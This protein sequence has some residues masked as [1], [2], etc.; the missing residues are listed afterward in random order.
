MYLVFKTIHVVAAIVWLGAGLTFQVMNRRVRADA[1]RTGFL[2]EQG[3]W[4]GRIFFPAAAVTT[5]VAGI[6][7]VLVSDLSFGDLWITVGFVGIAASILVGAVFISRTT[8]ALQ[9]ATDA[10]DA[11]GMR[12]AASRLDLLGWVDMAI[13]FTVVGFMVYKPV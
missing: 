7:M 9:V 4:F 13:L 8:A 11:A 1:T 10:G 6:V 2:A 5:L 3:A 12:A